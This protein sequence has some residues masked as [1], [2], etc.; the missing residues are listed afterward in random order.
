MIYH[1]SKKNVDVKNMK[2]ISTASSIQLLISKWTRI[3]LMLVVGI[4]R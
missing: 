3:T 1:L 4:K 2:S